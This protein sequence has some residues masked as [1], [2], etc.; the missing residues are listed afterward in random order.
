MKGIHLPI[1][2]FPKEGK[3][4]IKPPDPLSGMPEMDTFI[5]M[6][7]PAKRL[8]PA[9]LT[10]KYSHATS[11]PSSCRENRKLYPCMRHDE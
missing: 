1:L 3:L 6:H 2:V 9:P 10:T 4:Y 11:A 7:F 8:A 5:L